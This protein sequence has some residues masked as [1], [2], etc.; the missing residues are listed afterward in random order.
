MFYEGSKKEIR[1]SYE[2]K[3]DSSERVISMK[4][5]NHNQQTQTSDFAFC[6]GDFK[7]GAVTRK[8]YCLTSQASEMSKGVFTYALFSL[9]S[10]S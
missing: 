2:G 9:V 10:E 1:L 6:V 7:N 4:S 8:Q 5:S 3:G